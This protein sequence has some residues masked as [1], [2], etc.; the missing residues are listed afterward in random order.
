VTAF[1]ADIV[2]QHLHQWIPP[3]TIDA[4]TMV[5]ILS[6]TSPGWKM[7]AALANVSQALM[8]GTGC[9]FFR[10][11]SCGDL[12]HC[13]R[14][15]VGKQQK[16][17]EGFYAR[18]DGTL[19]FYFSEEN[20][21]RLFEAAGFR[22]ERL[23]TVSRTK[24]NRKT[25]LSMERKFIQGT[26]VLEDPRKACEAAK[27]AKLAAMAAEGMEKTGIRGHGG[28]TTEAKEELGKME[29]EVDLTLGPLKLQLKVPPT[30]DSSSYS[31]LGSVGIKSSSIVLARIVLACPKLF[32]N[33]VVCEVSCG[34]TGLP[35][36][37]ALRWCKR[38]IATDTSPLEISFFR[39][40]AE[41]NCH[42]FVCER[43]RIC[44][45]GKELDGQADT[46]LAAMQRSTITDTSLT[47]GKEY[48]AGVDDMLG[49]ASRMLSH[50]HGAFVLVCLE[51][52]DDLVELAALR[53]GLTVCPP[54]VQLQDAL[55][56][57]EMYG[58]VVRY[59][60]MCEGGLGSCSE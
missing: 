18:G 7:M 30:L 35:S 3:S 23:E 36:L 34:T 12:A 6:A 22:C 49:I 54:P 11:Y 38:A 5:F 51:D 31:G 24:T 9:I 27:Q 37:A 20:A 57:V 59:L 42:R 1:V 41:L 44:S 48:I 10:D 46:V 16:I 21:K 53:H 17:S 15:A 32:S 33:R 55:R 52:G 19:A 28:P 29:K 50:K 14:Q 26:F 4:C 45:P 2:D 8:P 43:L 56:V 13:R 25:G 60:E 39:R 47:K 58:N 40:N